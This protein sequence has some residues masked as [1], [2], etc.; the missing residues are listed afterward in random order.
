MNTPARKSIRIIQGLSRALWWLGEH[1]FVCVLFLFGIA[2]GLA[3]AVFWAYVASP[4]RQADFQQL[5]DYE[6]R[7]ELFSQT[8]EIKKARAGAFQSAQESVSGDIFEDQ[9]FDQTPL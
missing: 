8:A 5:S 2:V 4:G 1:A 3:A 6:F 9:R 7:A